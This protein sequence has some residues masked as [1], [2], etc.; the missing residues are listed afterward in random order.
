[1]LSLFLLSFKKEKKEEEAIEAFG[2]S[3]SLA[4]HGIQIRW[5]WVVTDAPDKKKSH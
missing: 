1:M 3:D 4:G 5:I 2:E